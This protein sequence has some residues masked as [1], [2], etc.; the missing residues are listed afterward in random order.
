[1]RYRPLDQGNSW[2]IDQTRV[3][4][5]ESRNERKEVLTSDIMQSEKSRSAKMRSGPSDHRVSWTVDLT[6]QNNF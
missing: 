1:M 6:L 3:E 4:N 2:V 5:R